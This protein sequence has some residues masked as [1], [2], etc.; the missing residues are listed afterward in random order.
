MYRPVDEVKMQS[1]GPFADQD[2]FLRESNARRRG[3]AHICQKD[4]FPHCSSGCASYV[5]HIEH[6]L[7]KSFIENPWL[8]FEGR[9]G[10]F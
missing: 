7:G 8:D 1:V 6:G 10:G 9:L 4:A 5:L 3:Q 2:S